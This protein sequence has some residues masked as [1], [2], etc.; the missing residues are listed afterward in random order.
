[1][2][3]SEEYMSK[4]QI[5][6]D[7]DFNQVILPLGPSQFPYIHLHQ[8]FIILFLFIVCNITSHTQYF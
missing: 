1:M 8:S 3:H 4:L 2:K 6:K 7:V 5:K